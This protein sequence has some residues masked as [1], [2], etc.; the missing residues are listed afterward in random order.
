MSVCYHSMATKPAIVKTNWKSIAYVLLLLLSV[1][2]GVLGTCPPVCTCAS[3]IVICTNK[4]LSVVPRTHFKFIKKLDLSYNK[5]GFLD[6]DW[7]PFLFER[8]DTLILNHNTVSSISTG[9]FSTIPNVRY[10][11]LSSNNLRTLSNPVFQEL[12]MLEVLLLYNN[13]LTHID[14]GAFGGLHKLQ[15]LYLSGNVLTQFPL[16]LFVG[17]TKLSELVLL[18]MSYNKLQ[19]VPIKQ[20]SLIPARQLSGIY[21][22]ENPFI[23]DCTLNSMLSFW[24]HR[25]FSPVLDF[26]NDYSCTLLSDPKTKLLFIQDNFLNCSENTVNESFHAF[27]FLYEAQV[28]E[29]LVVNCDSQIIDANTQFVWI[30][31]DNRTLEPD[32]GTNHFHVFYNGSLEIEDAQIGDSGVYSCIAINKKRLINETVDIRI[33]VSNFTT[34]K[35]QSHEA[36]N[37]AF[38]TLA[39]CVVSIVLVLL[40]LYLTPC[41]CW[42]KSKKKKRKPNQNSAHSSMLSATPPNEAQNERKSSTGKRVVFLEPVKGKEQGQNGKVR[43]IGNENLIGESILKNN[44]S[45]SDS[46]SVSSVFSDAPFIASV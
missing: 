37:T 31:P 30:S 7:F 23:C 1:F 21:I 46:D 32:I 25:H 27:G 17:R 3:D 40:Y 42:C 10:L 15:K 18:D 35:S 22:H 16:D 6:P 26:K 5:I 39:A 45:K 24:Y 13:Q 8:L 11:D 34:T 28:G 12:K 20:I 44:R 33:T 36:F 19:T 14:S 4:N 9:S 29:R 38:T 2:G 41:R 43:L